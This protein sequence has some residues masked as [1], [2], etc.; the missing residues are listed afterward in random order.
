MHFTEKKGQRLAV[1][2]HLVSP[3]TGQHIEIPITSPEM[4]ASMLEA[5]TFGRRGLAS[6]LDPRDPAAALLNKD[7]TTG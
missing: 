3:E 4:E 1:F 7:Y 5:E 2:D 6:I